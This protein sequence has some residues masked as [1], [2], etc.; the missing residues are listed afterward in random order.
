M[1][2]KK[3]GAEEST[4][5]G[6]SVVPQASSKS[7]SRIASGSYLLWISTAILLAGA[8]YLLTARNNSSS[9]QSSGAI[10]PAI[11]PESYGLCTEPG[12]IYTVDEATP[13]VDC[14]VIR[15]DEVLATGSRGQSFLYDIFVIV[16][17]LSF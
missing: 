10:L 3:T 2:A 1:N 6:K 15:K 17:N 7:P 13:I 12:K 5:M 9:V 8:S 4:Q 16:P 14:I 11:L